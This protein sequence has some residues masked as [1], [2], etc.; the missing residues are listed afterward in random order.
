MAELQPLMPAAVWTFDTTQVGWAD[1]AARL[2]T[3]IFRG[4]LPGR[5]ATE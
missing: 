1:I 3:E 4:G 5:V 2:A